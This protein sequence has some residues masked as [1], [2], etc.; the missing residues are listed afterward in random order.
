MSADGQFSQLVLLGCD[1]ALYLVDIVL[2]IVVELSNV[3]LFF[4]NKEL[5]Y[6]DKVISL[7]FL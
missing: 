1:M 3:S 4:W 7:W 6:I 5:A 2:L